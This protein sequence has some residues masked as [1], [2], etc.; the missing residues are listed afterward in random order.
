M[1]QKQRT[2]IDPNRSNI[3]DRIEDV[4]LNYTS[5]M[6]TNYKDATRARYFSSH[7]KPDRKY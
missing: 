7:E 3:D 1:L 2:S 5:S 4:S 6:K